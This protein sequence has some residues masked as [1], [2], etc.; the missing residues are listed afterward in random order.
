MLD[1]II[2]MIIVAVVAL[3]VSVYYMCTGGYDIQD[4][5]KGAH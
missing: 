5:H 2:L 4:K 3:A 1:F